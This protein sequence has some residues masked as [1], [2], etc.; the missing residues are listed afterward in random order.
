MTQLSGRIGRI[1]CLPGQRGR[2]GKRI[3]PI[4]RFSFLLYCF[5]YIADC[6]LVLALSLNRN[7]Y[8]SSH[9]ESVQ[10]LYDGFARDLLIVVGPA[11]K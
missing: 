4:N 2:E 9:F 10:L 1:G 8:I 3:E 5:V 6:T 7:F 11:G